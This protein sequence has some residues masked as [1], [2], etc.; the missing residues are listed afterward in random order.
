M[1]FIRSR[2]LLQK[3]F[4]LALSNSLEKLLGILMPVKRKIPDRF[5]PVSISLPAWEHTSFLP[6]NLVLIRSQQNHYW[7]FCG[8]YSDTSSMLQYCSIKVSAK[9]QTIAFYPNFDYFW[10]FDY[11]FVK[12]DQLVTNFTILMPVIITIDLDQWLMHRSY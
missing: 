7:F 9:Y 2:L 1:I 3:K 10:E 12:V 11:R 4:M 6:V 5:N 8:Q